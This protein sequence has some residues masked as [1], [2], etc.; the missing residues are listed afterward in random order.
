MRVTG[1][2]LLEQADRET[3][4]AVEVF[5]PLPHSVIARLLTRAVAG[6]NWL[7][8]EIQD[9]AVLISDDWV[10]SIYGEKLIDCVSAMCA[11]INSISWE[12]DS[13]VAIEMLTP[14]KKND[15]PL[16]R[17]MERESR[18]SRAMAA[19]KWGSTILAS[20]IAGALLQWLLGGG[21]SL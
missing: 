11:L 13:A 7:A 17:Q 21:L 9:A 5:R 2:P 8:S 12:L 15:H 18:R 4:M 3:L 20:A 1:R 14:V 16:Y 10:V 19:F 6:P